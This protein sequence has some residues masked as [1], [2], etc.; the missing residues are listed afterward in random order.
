MIYGRA[1]WGVGR[2]LQAR[3][4]VGHE[5]P[6]RQGLGR[7]YGHPRARA[8]V[9]VGESAVNYGRA[10]ESPVNTGTL[11]LGLGLRLGSRP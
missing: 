11:G 6:A 5:L 8:Q 2:E 9:E 3:R 7:K 4:G 10:G 1:A